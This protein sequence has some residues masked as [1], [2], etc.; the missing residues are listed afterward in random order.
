VTALLGGL[1]FAAYVGSGIWALICA[2]GQAYEYHR[3]LAGDRGREIWDR[4]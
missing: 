1:F 2:I 4:T 3:E